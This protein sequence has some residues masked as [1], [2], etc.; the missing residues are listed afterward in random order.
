MNALKE[1]SQQE[2]GLTG[3]NFDENIP[4]SEKIEKALML[5]DTIMPI[6]YS[7]NIPIDAIWDGSVD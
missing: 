4:E 3:R 2:Y 1:L 5:Y 7:R 6:L